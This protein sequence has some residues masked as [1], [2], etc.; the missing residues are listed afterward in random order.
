MG[1][2]QIISGGTD[3]QYQVRVLYNRTWLTAKLAQLADQIASLQTRLAGLPEGD[4]KKATELQLAAIQKSKSYFEALPADP[5][6][7]A[8]CADLSEALTGTVGTIEIGGQYA[9]DKV[10]IRPGY[11]GR[12]NYNATRDGQLLHIKCMSAEQAY[13][14]MAMAPGWQKWMPTYRVGELTAKSGDSGDVQLDTLLTAYHRDA[15]LDVTGT[16]KNIYSAAIEYMDC[17]GDAFE[18]GD[19][20]VVEFRNRSASGTETPV[21]IGFESHPKPCKVERFLR[22]ATLTGRTIK[23][24]DET[25]TLLKSI[26]LNTY[27]G[28]PTGTGSG[29]LVYWYMASG[30]CN[31]LVVKT[32]V[33]D[34]R[35]LG[36]NDYLCVRVPIETEAGEAV[37]QDLRGTFDVM[38]TCTKFG[39]RYYKVD[40]FWGN[41]DSD[42]FA[43]YLHGQ[44]LIAD[45]T[46]S[47]YSGG[48]YIPPD[49]EDYY[50]APAGPIGHLAGYVFAPILVTGMT[51][52]WVWHYSEISGTKLWQAGGL[53]GGFLADGT[54]LFALTTEEA[55]T[56]REVIPWDGKIYTFHDSY[57]YY[58]YRATVC[59]VWDMSTGELLTQ[60]T[61]HEWHYIDR[62]EIQQWGERTVFAIRFMD[63]WG[64]FGTQYY[65]DLMLYDVETMEVVGSV[66][67]GAEG[68]AVTFLSSPAPDDYMTAQINAVRSDQPPIYR[69]MPGFTP[70]YYYQPVSW[71]GY[72]A[73]LS[74]VAQAHISWCAQN[75]Q[76][77]HQDAND[78]LVYVRA[79]P[80]GAMVAAENLAY[81]PYQ[82]NIE[83][84]IDAAIAGW[85]TSPS[86]KATMVQYDHLA[87]G[88]GVA[89][90][91]YSY[92]TL[93]IGP[94]MW[95]G[96]EYTDDWTEIEIPEY[97]RGQIR[98]YCTV[99]AG[100]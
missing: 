80:Y 84:E 79:L 82:A 75:G 99:F 63:V 86:H 53:E 46:E 45:I 98:L 28:T 6:I 58:P 24:W 38:A 87:V 48:S 56:M 100:G 15:S 30:E 34:W 17:N 95:T 76:M 94:G 39:T 3:G 65:S 50:I 16:A 7:T 96:S 69:P 5:E 20:V 29:S 54:R 19:R 81:T 35:G 47:I 91:P 89:T 22:V 43:D 4:E 92:T 9:W 18:V 88:W 26:D 14:N 97:Q 66:P 51:G 41:S 25:G 90:V 83:D 49:Y 93:R 37:E 73:Q 70:S 40:S 71:L 64:D 59:R 78:D 61:I 12:S 62:A 32:W 33:N 67:I 2:G 77:S 13:Y 74:A 36:Y 55:T 11:D 10:L 21:I 85:L 44:G 68:A 52:M 42:M 27:L 1:K 72:S 8:W 57:P 23:I 60:Q 31:H